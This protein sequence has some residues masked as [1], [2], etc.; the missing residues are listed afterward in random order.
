MMNK[1][2]IYNVAP[3]IP[4]NIQFVE[5]LSKNLWWTWNSSAK[6][7]FRRIDPSLWY[8]YDRNPL[9][10]LFHV[11][12]QRMQELSE[13]HGFLSHL[14]EVRQEFYEAVEKHLENSISEDC[15]A[16]FSLEY[17]LHESIRIY[18]GGLGILAGDHLK[19]ASDMDFDLVGVGLF[20]REG[21]FRQHLDNDG[22]QEESYPANRLQYMPFDKVRHDNGE[23]IVIELNLPDGVAKAVVWKARVGRTLL[24]LLDANLP[25]NQPQHRD[26]TSRLYGGNRE[27]RLR[28]ELLL[29]VGGFDALLQMGYKPKVCHINEGHAAFLNI[30]RLNHFVV[31]HNTSFEE[32]LEFAPKTKV[33]TTHTPVPAGHESFRL[34]LLKPHLKA[35]MK[36]YKIDIEHIF[37]LAQLPGK[38]QR[39]DHKT[40]LSMTVLALRTSFFSNGVSQLH[41]RVSRDMWSHL[42]PKHSKEEIPIHYITNGVH[43][44]TWVTEEISLL[45]ER[46]IGSGWEKSDFNG[47]ESKAIDGILPEELWHAHQIAGSRLIATIRRRLQHSLEMKKA[48][49]YEI[50][51]AENVLDDKVLT[52]GFAR[53]FASYKRANLILKDMERL[54]KLLLDKDHP[55]QIIFAGKAHPQDEKG[56][57][58]IQQ[59]YA[60]TKDPALR[61]RIVFLEDYD[62]FIAERMIQGVDVWLNNPKRP[63][64]ASGT[65][66][67][68]AALNGAINFSVLDGWW[69]EAYNEKNGWAIGTGEIYEDQEYQ[70]HVEAQHLYNTLENEII[71]LYYKNKNGIIPE[72]WTNTMK[73][74]IKTVLARFSSHRMV[75]EYLEYTYKPALDNYNNLISNNMEHCRKSARLHDELLAIWDKIQITELDTDRNLSA[76]RVGEQFTVTATVFL[77]DISAEL[78][79]LEVFYGPVGPMNTL[80]ESH[81]VKMEVIE[82]LGD[83]Y[84]KYSS[85]INCSYAGRYGLTV[86]AVPRDK[87]WKDTMPGMITWA[88]L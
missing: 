67:M 48:P 75:K 35:V 50:E 87:A 38:E 25:D 83:G 82:T 61:R 4:E 85:V 6:N 41:G 13:D 46:Y 70:D 27:M 72:E 9:A 21:Y 34:D 3:T 31:S 63:R 24:F 55:I 26:I 23:E 39:D 64:E 12:Q 57:Q 52:I 53:R 36:D 18:S 20:Y 45:L 5:T 19:A 76:L 14:E 60:L 86:R 79:D 10:L 8:R 81:T 1:L 42:W 54:K 49:A 65:S 11:S 43:L 47:G 40:E 74:S 68:K 51:Q 66:G 7:L 44:P 56:K 88:E 71:P 80:E 17:G 15:I 62:M 28:Q 69:A 33:F 16:Y 2:K 84:F 78:V 22:L 58:I 73:E 30:A 59:V 32:A 29:G 37:T 77:D